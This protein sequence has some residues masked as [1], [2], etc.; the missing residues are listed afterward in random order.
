M[1]GL[2]IGGA[3][4]Q[5]AAVQVGVP[6]VIGKSRADAEADLGQLGL[7]ARVEEIEAIGPVGTVYAQD[8]MP[9]ARRAKGF[10]VLL[11][12]VRAVPGPPPDLSA[13]L[14]AL[15]AV[16]DKVDSALTALTATAGGLETDTAAG[17]RHGQVTTALQQISDKLDRLTKITPTKKRT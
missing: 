3:P 14:D 12:I 5:T 16:V 7:R 2:V 8:P 11:H 15:K 10:A 6:N 17:T 1:Q 4:G 13:K 9:P